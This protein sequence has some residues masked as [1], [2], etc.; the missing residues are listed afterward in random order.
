[1]AVDASAALCALDAVCAATPEET[2]AERAGI[3]ALES[4][5]EAVIARLTRGHS[6]DRV[7]T[8][9]SGMDASAV[10]HY[11]RAFGG[12]STWV[13]VGF[14]GLVLLGTVLTMRRPRTDITGSV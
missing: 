5:L 9:R 1:M 14:C 8:Q 7:W 11:R 12:G 13:P 3:A 4:Q 6:T 2:T 10:Y